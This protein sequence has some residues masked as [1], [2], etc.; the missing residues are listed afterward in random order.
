MT[1][2]IDH[3]RRNLLF[4]RRPE[5]PPP[6]RPPWTDEAALAGSCTRCAACVEACEPGLISFG[7][8][9][10]PM[11]DFTAGE[12]TFCAACA[13]ACPEPVFP[14]APER[15]RAFSHIVSIGS[16]ASPCLTLQG[17][18]CQTC[19]DECAAAAIRFDLRIGRPAIPRIV[20]DLC[21]GCGA[22]LAACPVGAIE[23]GRRA[24]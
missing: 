2:A 16:S 14:D 12:C 5:A 8:G 3:S 4:G 7:A 18:V 11:I 6:I 9:D 17:V 21:T 1:Q 20:E 13:D 10:L 15:G 24:S 23:I 22:C 19:R